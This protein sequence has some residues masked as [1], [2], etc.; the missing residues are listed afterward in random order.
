MRWNRCSAR[1]LEP[2]ELD[3]VSY[4]AVDLPPVEDGNVIDL[5]QRGE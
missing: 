2:N 3:R 1:G 4:M 5:R